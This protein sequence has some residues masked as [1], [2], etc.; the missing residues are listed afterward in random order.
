MYKNITPEGW[1]AQF[2][3]ARQQGF[4]NYQEDAGE[5]MELE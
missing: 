4:Q 5:P 3:A 2:Q 1:T